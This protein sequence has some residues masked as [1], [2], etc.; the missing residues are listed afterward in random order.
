[1]GL[2]PSFQSFLNVWSNVRM[3]C[4]CVL[5][6]SVKDGMLQQGQDSFVET[7]FPSSTPFYREKVVLD[8]G[9]IHWGLIHQVFGAVC[10]TFIRLYLTFKTHLRTE[11]RY[12]TRLSGC[13]IICT[14][15]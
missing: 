10:L 14:I 8:S 5:V 12:L 6:A 4:W 7:T 3:W 15:L 9:S 11:L 2:S 13:T 1:V